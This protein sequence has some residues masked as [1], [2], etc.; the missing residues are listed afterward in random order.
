MRRESQEEQ[1][2][3]GGHESGKDVG[4]TSHHAQHFLTRPAMPTRRAAENAE[5]PLRNWLISFS[6]L[7]ALGHSTAPDA[8]AQT[9]VDICS[10]TAGVQTAILTAINSAGT[11]TTC[12][13]VTD[14][15]LADV[16]TIRASNHAITSLQSGDFAGLTS[17]RNLALWGNAITTLPSDIFT[18]LT[19]LTSL[20][21][22][23]NDITILPANI[24]TGLTALTRLDL[25]KN[26]ITT[27]PANVF[28][29][30]TALT[31][32]ELNRN[33]ITT[34]QAG[35]FAS[36]TALTRL[37]LEHNGITTLPAGS[38]TDLPELTR[39]RLSS[40]DITTLP[41]GIFANLT[42]LE[43]LEL[44]R[45]DI[46]T[47][48]AGIFANLTALSNLYL[49][50]NDFATLQDG[51]FMGLTALTTLSLDNNEITTL[52]AGVFANLSALERLDLDSNNI[53][54]LPAG[55]FMGLT[56]LTSIG[57][58]GN[59]GVP[60]P[61]TVTLDRIDGENDANSPATVVA[62]V[63]E[64]A[65]AAIVV[66]LNVSSRTATF[67]GGSSDMSTTIPVGNTLSP[68]FTVTGTTY[69]TVSIADFSGQFASN[70]RL[71]AGDPLQIFAD[72]APTAAPTS[73]M[74]VAGDTQITVS[75]TAVA[76]ADDGGI[77]ITG[78]TATVTDTTNAANTFTCTAT[79]PTAMAC[80][81]PITDL[82][83]RVVYS[84]TVVA[85]NSVGSSA[86]SVMV[87]V[88][89][90]GP[91]TFGAASIAEQSYR[92]G[93]A[94]TVTL[95]Q[96]TGGTGTLSYSLMPDDSI[97]AGL[98]FTPGTRT[99]TSTPT[100]VMSAATLTY[101]VTDS[102]TPTAVTAALTFTVTVDKG[103]QTGFGF[104]IATVSK[105]VGDAA[106]T[107]TASGGSGIGAVTYASGDST[108]ARVND[109]SG[110]VTIVAV[111]STTIT[112]TKAAD[113]NYNETRATY[114]LTVTAAILTF[115]AASITE[116]SYRVGT[117]VTVTL[118]QATG[119]T[120]TL[121]YSLMPDDSIPAG[122]SF[123][124][125]TRTLTSTP[126][127]VMSAATLTYTV[128]DSATPTAVTA[129]LTFTVTVD[130]G[131]QTGF[132]F[133]VAT[134]SKMVGDA[135]FTETASGG[136]GIG[137]VTYAS[138]D[139]TVARVNDSSG[140]VTIVAVGSTTITATKA[141]NTNYNEATATYALTVTAA[142]LTFGAASITEQSYRV[143]T[144]V[145]VTLPQATGGTGTLSYSL[146][147]DDSIPAGL[148][149]TPGTR[150]L[151]STPTAVMSAATLTYTV[152]DSATPT[153][154]T[155]ALT[156]TV[157]VDKGEQTGFGF[158]V[159]TVSKMVG[160]A[161][162]TETASGGSGIGAVTY[163]SGDTAVAS[164]NTNSGEVTILSV[165]TATITATKAADAN[166]NG[167]TATYALTVTAAILT[168]G[169]ASI[170][171]QSYRV[172]TAVTVTLP[173]ATGGTGTLSYSLMPDGSIPAGLTFDTADR[174]LTGAP[175]AAM[176]AA[177]L[178][179]TVT[180]SA[181]PTA[182]T[183][184]L[185]FTVTVDKGEQTGFGFAVATVS[186]MVGD[187]AFTE[188]ASGGS[189]IGAVTYASG[190]TAVA[191]VNTNSGEV[192]ILSVGTATITATKAADANYNG[193]T[194]T[195]ALTVTAAILTF[196][197]A[198]IIEQ[199]YRVGTA[200]TVTLPQAT[201]GT[202]TLS[203]S[204]MPD[205]SIPAGLTF[206]T[207]DRILTG[208]PTAAMSAATLTYTVT[209]SATPTAVTTALTFTVTVVKGEQ[210][211][212]GF[213]VATVSKMVGDAAF[214]ETASGGAGIGAVTYASGDSAVARVNDSSGLVTIVA[215]GS[216]TI[217]ATKA[218]DT[219]YNETRATYAL[220]VTA[221][222]TGVLNEQILS[223]TA[224]AITASAVAAMAGRVEF[225]AGGGSSVPAYLFDG[226]S[227]LRGLFDAHGK[228][229]LE[230]KM[231]YER[232]LDGASF[233]LPLSAAEGD[234]AGNI[235]ATALW[236]STDYR[237]LDG[238]EDNLKWDGEVVSFH[239]GMDKRFI[240]QTLGG[241]A[242]SWNQ[243]DFGY[244]DTA[245]RAGS[246]GEYQYNSVNLHPYF[247]WMPNDDLTIWG[248]VGYGTG[249]IEVNAG[250]VECS[251][252][253]T[254][255]SMSG[256]FSR[257]LLN[258]TELMS[259]GATTLNLK[260]DVS[261]TSVDVEENQK[262]SFAA[263]EVGSS[264][265]RVLA[266]GEQQRELT[267][268]GVLIPSLEMGVRY[269]GG[270]GITGAGAE[271]GGGLRYANPGGNFTVAGNVRTLLAHDYNESG[272]DFLLR[273]S[274]A[275]GRGLSLRVRPAWGK[276]QSVADKL[277]N[278]GAN[279]LG[280]GNAALQ[281]SLDAEV[282]YGVAATML[283]TPG[284]VTPYTGMTATD[285]VPNR[286]RLGGR[287]AGGNG[288]S[289]NLEGARKNTSDSV[290]HTV[291][292]R[293]EIAF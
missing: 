99:L 208:A 265:L 107:E 23:G 83:N 279:E 272:A 28:M 259:G 211:G 27:L 6:L 194:A 257:W 291:L 79:G 70:F 188:T 173:Q 225:V 127:A 219:N 137:A 96:A 213:A 197:A 120:G 51:V 174:I 253:T 11:T 72:T 165:G 163:A 152:T 102:A 179:Y 192:T 8:L 109:S 183:T 222:P 146:M 86:P 237:R 168:F 181:T 41:I 7:C 14:E 131:E 244:H 128:T 10:R 153:A 276:T 106:F 202:G 119:G 132:G 155:A 170:I 190:D 44:N 228:S 126:T 134:V 166:Y 40:N 283:G 232:L 239:L 111:G 12:E 233:A 231:E 178:T 124:P 67:S 49:N 97:P 280:G 268:G 30:L 123:T 254:Q 66:N 114:A 217:T 182:V 242:L 138:G 270:D 89:P 48:P 189:G 191:S 264:R 45:N 144:A 258:S 247:G 223:R 277:W 50:D 249:E 80:D 68:F 293:G 273:L 47:L 76:E 46:T 186:K 118:P 195:Y 140:L 275:S 172:G 25:D 100:A 95:P 176:S 38:F 220:T 24:F 184:A 167:A 251:T 92:V 13:T 65:P 82:T 62:K 110:L 230:G 148:S 282:G 218:A 17:L 234:S 241:V 113:T 34:L 115:G 20:E 121:S 145:T 175:T 1:S 84:V 207:A 15:Q 130:K 177:T 64:G 151:T 252:D 139:S 57:L 271:L 262:D 3:A 243:S 142:I 54:T 85:T 210:T 141:T 69:S 229:M 2:E 147:P 203:Y 56:A 292:L 266:S 21:L 93:T 260:G 73:V 200:V 235:G 156:F 129:A 90:V 169:A 281:S 4:V 61:L 198:S 71:M 227:S 274:P 22:D 214:T 187:A 43:R 201:G 285:G 32:L 37:E 39:L 193:A 112:A 269:D 284:V 215:V 236:G 77:A 103:E 196:G 125:G 246:H 289:L 105:M 250:G 216:T 160:D 122:L 255:L 171:E 31:R 33:N 245:N 150:T 29:G 157:T 224:Q 248:T 36:L 212:F 154:V 26:G 135:A 161:A 63:A 206:D 278:D 164:V 60:F 286:V 287:F 91:L 199:S 133:A 16:T 19:T 52:P 117:A 240:R 5:K 59:P 42:A 221:A 288:I 149:F 9:T 204:L 263:Q 136:S 53:E 261:I 81:S 162:F 94:V 88:T 74:L 87:V 101:T 290:S 108:V 180:D 158:A 209:D 238:D 98:S 58:S 104:V 75:W 18:G 78:Y 205:G 185:T 267:S 143:G 55:I 116:Q 226:Q 35:I 256:G 159:A